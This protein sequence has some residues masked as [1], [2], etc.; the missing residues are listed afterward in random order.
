MTEFLHHP[1]TQGILT[2]ALGAAAADFAAFRTWKTWHEA[3]V[4]SWGTA[5]FRWFQGAVVG[6]VS[7][8]GLR[9]V[10]GG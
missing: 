4:Y 5:S 2:G 10:T 3:I 6:L 1:I 7:S 9:L 8:L